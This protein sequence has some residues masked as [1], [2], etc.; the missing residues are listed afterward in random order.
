MKRVTV[1][2]QLDFDWENNLLQFVDES[3]LDKEYQVR[4]TVA[5]TFEVDFTNEMPRTWD[6]PGEP[7]EWEV[8]LLLITLN[9]I[10]ASPELLQGGHL[11]ELEEVA[12]Y[13]YDK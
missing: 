12:V 11:E 3:T 8:N 2:R 1:Q 6:T 13:E 9:G 5:A 10:E 4:I 7:A